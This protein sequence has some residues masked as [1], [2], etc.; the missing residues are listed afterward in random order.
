[1]NDRN[2]GALVVVDG[3]NRAVGIVTD[4]DITIRVT[5]QGR[6]PV[7]TTVA[8]IMTNNPITALEISTAREALFAMRAGRFRRLP[9]VDHDHQIVGIVTL[10]DL[11][12]MFATFLSD[13]H[14]VI[15][16]ERP[17]ALAEDHHH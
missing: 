1:M 3:E 4:R 14:A 9:V 15:Q 13:V 16:T 11:L 2:V 8:E 12:D 6:N 10:D 17:A 5:A 7:S